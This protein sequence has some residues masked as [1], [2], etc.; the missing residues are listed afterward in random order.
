M[1]PPD[2]LAPSP[3]PPR[4]AP[5]A[6]AGRAPARARSRPSASTSR[7]SASRSS[8]GWP[9]AATSCSARSSGSCRWSPPSCSGRRSTPGSGQTQLAGFRYREMIAYLLLTHISR[10]F[11]SM[12]GL[13]GG[14]ARDIRDGT[15][16]NYLIQPLDMIGYLLSLPGRAQGRLHRHVVP[17][18]RPPVL[19][20]PRASSTASPTPPTLAAY[21]VSLLLAFLVG[22]FFEA[23]VGM[24]GLLVPGSDVAAVHRDDAELLHLGPHAPAR[25]AAPALVGAAE[26]RCRSSTWR[27]SRRWSSWAR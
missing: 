22:F 10:M 16:K 7:S 11:S 13:A 17:A 27:T 20:L 18:L 4:A 24:V 1:T 2:A 9:T 6:I 19:P 21:A 12:P 23:C 15:L 26:G 3:S 25:P 14:I 8:S 5:S